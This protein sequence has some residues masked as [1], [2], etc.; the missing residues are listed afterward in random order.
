MKLTILFLL[1]IETFSFL[2]KKEDVDKTKRYNLSFPITRYTL[3]LALYFQKFIPISYC[4][5]EDIENSPSKCC[6]KETLSDGWKRYNQSSHEIKGTT[7]NRLWRY[8]LGWFDDYKYNFQIFVNDKNRKILV[9]FPGTRKNLKQILKEVIQSRMVSGIDANIKEV[10]AV[11]YFYDKYLLIREKMF[12]TLDWLLTKKTERRKYQFIFEGHSLGGAIATLA[13]YDYGNKNDKFYKP[14]FRQLPVLITYGAPVVGNQLFVNVL[15]KK[16]PI[17][18][19][20]VKEN[21]SIPYLIKEPHPK[22]L[23]MITKDGTKAFNCK[24]SRLRKNDICKKSS[25]FKFTSPIT[26]YFNTKEAHSTY[27]ETFSITD[28]ENCINLW[29][30]KSKIFKF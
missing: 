28:H 18:I 1:L 4:Y 25:N 17:I 14:K 5:N 27:F 11:K 13:A 29:N 22:G 19:R 20:V 9:L 7:H 10:K 15:E 3:P 21:D 8:T 16:I 30:D 2:S 23:V 26:S 12:A 24:G 6:E